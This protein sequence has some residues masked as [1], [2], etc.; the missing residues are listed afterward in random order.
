[1]NPNDTSRAA[2]P[3]LRRA[4]ARLRQNLQVAWRAI[5][6]ESVLID[7]TTG[8][9]FVLNGVGSRV[10]SL[11]EEPRTQDELTDTIAA[12][13]EL[14]ADAIAPD[15]D[16]FVASLDERRLIEVMP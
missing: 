11:L 13:H 7:P 10:W 15:I 16:A 6:G 2:L 14:P 12:E 4:G 9:V 8:T 3:E 1:M 5:D